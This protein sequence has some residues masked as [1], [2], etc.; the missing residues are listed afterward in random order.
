MVEMGKPS[1]AARI[2]VAPAPVPTP[3]RK[4]GEAVNAP[5]TSPLPEK[6][7]MSAS[8]KKTDATQPEKV[9]IVASVI[10]VL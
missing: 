8:A 10:A 2:T 7:W 3:S 6:A 5:G 1:R 4:I 9:A